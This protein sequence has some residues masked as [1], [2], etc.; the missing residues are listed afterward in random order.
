MT[1]EPLDG[2]DALRLSME[3]KLTLLKQAEGLTYKLSEALKT[4]DDALCSK[5]LEMRRVMFEKVDQINAKIEGPKR[6]AAEAEAERSVKASAEASAALDELRD[7]ARAVISRILELDQ[8]SI[9]QVKADQTR[10]STELRRL[11]EGL[12]A[13][14]AYHRE[15][16]DDPR[17]LDKLK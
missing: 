9:E 10:I 15:P 1:R 16:A 8:A 14:K 6:Q 17:F 12:K 4:G 11:Q 3:T 7:E 5:L 13:R 2:T